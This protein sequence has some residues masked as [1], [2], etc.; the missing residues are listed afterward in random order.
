[1]IEIGIFIQVVILF[2][3]I[4]DPPASLAVFIAA[5][6]SMKSAE[7]RRTATYAIL[8]A[9]GVSLVVLLLGE[10]LLEFFTTTIDEFRIAGGIILGILGI[11]MAM[12]Y[13]LRAIDTM[14]KN[15]AFAIAAIIG[16]PMLTGPAAITAIMLSI[17]DYGRIITFLAVAFVLIICG[18]L[19]YFSDRLSKIFGNMAIQILTTVLGLITLSWG[20]K[21]VTVGLLNIF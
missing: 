8:V 20:V 10:R 18:I 16:T 2:F 7:K 15:S 13:P 21:F 12:G 5:T 4:F 17:N 14:K 9:A 11:K 19:F 3:V 1:M 6:R